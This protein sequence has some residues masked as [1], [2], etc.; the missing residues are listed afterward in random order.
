MVGRRSKMSKKSFFFLLLFPL[1]ISGINPKDGEQPKPVYKDIPYVQD[2]SISYY[3]TGEH[4]ALLLKDISVNRDGQVRV[5]S[6]Q[7]LIVPDN[8]SQFYPGKFVEDISY[9]AVTPKKI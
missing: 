6:D 8:G 3:L 7:G 4:K 2:Y 1:L 5:L 9:A